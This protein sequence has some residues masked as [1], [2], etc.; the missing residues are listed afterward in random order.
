MI[1][2]KRGDLVQVVKDGKPDTFQAIVIERDETRY[3]LFIPGQGEVWWFDAE[4]LTLLNHGQLG[5][6]KSW[7]SKQKAED[8]SER[9]SRHMLAKQRA[10][11][12]KAPGEKKLTRPGDEAKEIAQTEWG[13]YP[14]YRHFLVVVHKDNFEAFVNEHGVNVSEEQRQMATTK[15]SITAA[16]FS[17]NTPSGRLGFVLTASLEGKAKTTF[18]CKEAVDDR[19]YTSLFVSLFL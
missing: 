17:S 7:K 3:G 14:G 6:L 2:F 9:K 10:E 13:D 4:Q 16:M 15:G 8:R 12:W 19:A 1:K 5:L 11:E 18:V